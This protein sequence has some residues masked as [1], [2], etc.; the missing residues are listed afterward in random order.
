MHP[1]RFLYVPYRVSRLPLAG[2]DQR[3]ARRL[4]RESTVRGLTR[5]ALVAVDRV[6]AAILNEPPLRVD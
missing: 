6:A 1:A 5:A 2:L 4:G 3:L